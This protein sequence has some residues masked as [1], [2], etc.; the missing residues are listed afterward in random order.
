MGTGDGREG[1]HVP[2]IVL[3]AGDP[4]TMTVYFKWPN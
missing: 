3:T 2:V 4:G 1:L